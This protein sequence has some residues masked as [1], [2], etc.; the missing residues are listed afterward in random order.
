MRTCAPPPRWPAWQ[1]AYSPTDSA[2]CPNRPAQLG[3]GSVA[4]RALVPALGWRFGH[5]TTHRY[6]AG[7]DQACLDRRLRHRHEGILDAGGGEPF[8]ELLVQCAMSIGLRILRGRDRFGGQALD[9]LYFRWS[10]VS[11]DWHA[12]RPPRSRLSQ[13]LVM[14]GLA[15][16]LA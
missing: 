3:C 2:T 7:H 16:C 15:K 9:T 10:D 4:V 13:G 1:W 8:P 11:H 14:Q 5:C 6:V 12:R